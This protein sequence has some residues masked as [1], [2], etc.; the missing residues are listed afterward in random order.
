LRISA[1]A[2]TTSASIAS[3]SNNSQTIIINNIVGYTSS[4]Q[5]AI[6]VSG[7]GVNSITTILGNLTVQGDTTTLNTAT[8]IV[9]DKLIVIASGS[10]NSAEADGGGIYISGADASVTWNS[11]Q[12]RIDVNK[13][14]NIVGN[15]TL[16]GTV[17]GTEI[18]QLSSSFNAIRDSYLIQSASVSSSIRTLNAYTASNNSN[19]SAINT[20]ITS[21]NTFTS[22]TYNTF[23]ESVEG[24]LGDLEDS[25][26]GAGIGSTVSDLIVSASASI[27]TNNNQTTLLQNIGTTLFGPLGVSASADNSKNSLV[28]LTNQINLQTASITILF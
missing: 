28:G 26:G 21:L 11:A 6:S 18:S 1:S 9:E 24:R 25:I 5:S 3:A 19:I 2:L 7:S 15:I 22:S 20:A 8:L 27:V 14:L 4:L 12:S 16:T 10:T 13:P 23:T 17:D